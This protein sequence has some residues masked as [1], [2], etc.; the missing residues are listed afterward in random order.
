MKCVLTP[1]LV[2]L[3]AACTP[4]PRPAPPEQDA[5]A[6]RAVTVPMRASEFGAPMVEVWFKTGA[7]RREWMVL[8]TGDGGFVT[9]YRRPAAGA[10]GRAVGEAVSGP[11]EPVAIEW[12]MIGDAWRQRVAGGVVERNDEARIPGCVGQALL[13]TWDGVEIDFGKNAVTLFPVGGVPAIDSRA[14][15]VRLPLRMLST[16][17]LGTT[18]SI[19]DRACTVVIDTG[20]N[21]FAAAPEKLLRALGHD[22]A[23]SD[24][25]SAVTPFV[26]FSTRAVKMD[27]V[28]RVGETELRL[29]GPGMA[30]DAR[31]ASLVA[32]DQIVL[33]VG[34]LRQYRV[35]RFDWSRQEVVLLK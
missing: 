16:Q 11:R 28:L 21:G 12:L 10:V 24:E 23:A 14:R 13:R 3:L 27:D 20:F 33:G 1:V 5:Q 7:V 35:V 22:T 8:D 17:E 6:E 9:L 2:A 25:V 18:G 19:R 31:A 32:E 26:A 30:F 29:V 34:F 4:A 15:P